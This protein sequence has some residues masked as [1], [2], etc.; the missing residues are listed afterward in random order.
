MGSLETSHF[1][2]ITLSSSNP[3]FKIC[4]TKRFNKMKEL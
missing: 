2:S 4:K 3:S 1:L